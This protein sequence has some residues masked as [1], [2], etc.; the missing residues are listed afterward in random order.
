MECF[1]CKKRTKLGQDRIAGLPPNFSLKGLQ[2]DLHDDCLL[3]NSCVL[4]KTEC[5]NI[6]CEVCEIFICIMCFIAS[7]QNHRIMKKEDLEHELRKKKVTLS[8]E[9]KVR[10]TKA[11]QFVKNA[12]RRRRNINAHLG[13]LECSIK[14]VFAK[15]IT[16]LQENEK[17]LIE[18]VRD[19]REEAGKQLESCIAD[20]KELIKNIERSDAKLTH[21]MTKDVKDDTLI[22]VR[23]NCIDLE[24]SLKNTSIEGAMSRLQAAE[25]AQFLPSEKGLLDLGHVEMDGKTA[26]RNVQREP[27]IADAGDIQPVPGVPTIADGSATETEELQVE[28]NDQV[29]DIPPAVQNGSLTIVK[30]VD[31]PDNLFGMAALSQDSVVVGYGG[32]RKGSDCFSLSGDQKQHLKSNVGH[33]WGIACLS[34]GQ[35]AVSC[36]N[37]CRVYGMLGVGAGMHCTVTESSRYLRLCSDRHS[38]IYA[39]NGNPDIFIFNGTYAKKVKVSTGRTKPLQICVTSSGVMVTNTCIRPST[40]TVF[41]QAGH[42]GSSIESTGHHDYMFAAVDDQD[43]VLV[44]RLGCWLSVLRLTRYTLDET[45]LVEETTFKQ[46]KLPHKANRW[47]VWCYMV[48]LTP[49]LLAFANGPH[50]YFI[51]IAD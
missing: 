5:K 6:F 34:H 19:I 35:T 50:L 23:L 16:L 29:V 2:D 41:D 25:N 12:E 11:K 47:G 18:E 30:K 45:T 39:V 48:S 13:E 38:N 36:D 51:E 7:H 31:L 42:E 15:K 3:P 20:Q 27:A 40:V 22:E 21:K 28:V 44:A 33:I 32:N 46:I 9:S 26:A 1:V 10:K 17:K 14:D 8:Q 4:H 37:T 24:N 49:N 43:R